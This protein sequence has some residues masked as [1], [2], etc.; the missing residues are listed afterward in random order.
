MAYGAYKY[1]ALRKKSL[2]AKPEKDWSGVVLR[3]LVYFGGSY[4]LAHAILFVL[5][6]M[7]VLPR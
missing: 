4:F 5:R 2:S 3:S 1:P 7:G 6:Q